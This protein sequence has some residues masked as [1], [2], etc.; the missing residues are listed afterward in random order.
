[1]DIHRLQ[2]PPRNRIGTQLERSFEYAKSIHIPHAI[3]GW[4][5]E[6]VTHPSYMYPEPYRR[7]SWLQYLKEST[8]I[9]I[10]LVNEV[11]WVRGTM[12]LYRC[13]RNHTSL[14]REAAGFHPGSLQENN[15]LFE[16]RQ[17][18]RSPCRQG[19]KGLCRSSNPTS[20]AFQPRGAS[21]K[22]GLLLERKNVTTGGK[23][24]PQVAVM[25]HSSKLARDA[26][27]DWLV[28]SENHRMFS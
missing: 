4:A 23:S 11:V 7:F 20:G 28:R 25:S 15:R 8:R 27:K 3:E 10:A 9:P 19:I 17:P 14:Q 13:M 26:E 16:S 24:S 5:D 12:G 18:G 1:M 21:L 6:H 2:W 22:D